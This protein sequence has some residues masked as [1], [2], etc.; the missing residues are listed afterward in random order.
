[1]PVLHRH[2]WAA[3]HKEKALGYTSGCVASLLP[4]D[5]KRSV[6]ILRLLKGR[7]RAIGGF[8]VYNSCRLGTGG[9]ECLWAML[10]T[11]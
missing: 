11:G 9:F 8:V 2:P 5:S 1:M 3:D 6:K 7:F 4:S 10:S